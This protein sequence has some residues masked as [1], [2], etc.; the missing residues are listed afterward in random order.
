MEGG[1]WFDQHSGKGLN[2]WSGEERSVG[3][4]LTLQRLIL[5]WQLCQS[6]E[7][8]PQPHIPLQ[9]LLQ[10]FSISCGSK[11]RSQPEEGH[12]NSWPAKDQLL[13]RK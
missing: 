5:R 8:I 10:V 9:I 13:P 2:I 12:P 7:T 3:S 6:W 4:V 1:T 11:L